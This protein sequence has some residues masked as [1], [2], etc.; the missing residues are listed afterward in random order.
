MK[1]V[2]ALAALSLTALT[3]A[4]PAQAQFLPNTYGSY[5]QPYYGNQGYG[6]DNSYNQGY[7]QGYNDGYTCGRNG[8]CQQ[9][10]YAN[11]GYYGGYG[12]GQPQTLQ[13]ALIQ[14]GVNLLLNSLHR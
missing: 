12:Y 7:N 8:Y 9:R 5:N 3:L 14:T 2:L 4:A 6:Y 10:S 13:G 11:Q 1:K